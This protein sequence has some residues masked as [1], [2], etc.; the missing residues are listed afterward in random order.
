MYITERKQSWI[1]RL[2]AV[3]ITYAI[4]SLLMLVIKGWGTLEVLLFLINALN[5][6]L[7][8]FFNHSFIITCLICILVGTVAAACLSHIVFLIFGILLALISLIT[9]IIY[10]KK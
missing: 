10:L 9:L 5:F 3:M 4:I 7:F 1:N 8:Q 6:V 2:G